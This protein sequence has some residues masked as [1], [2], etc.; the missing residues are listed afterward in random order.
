MIIDIVT[1]FATFG[2]IV[3][4][5]YTKL[6]KIS[7]WLLCQFVKRCLVFP[8]TSKFKELKNK[9]VAKLSVNK[10]SDDSM[11]KTIYNEIKKDPNLKIY[12]VTDE[13]ISI[14]NAL[15]Y[16]RNEIL[17]NAMDYI[18]ISKMGMELVILENEE[19][20]GYD[21]SLFIELTSYRQ[22]IFNA[23]AF[24]SLVAGFIA[25]A[26]C[27]SEEVRKIIAEKAFPFAT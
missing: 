27:G 9:P 6:E 7:A 8:K 11:I 21:R 4:T 18:V 15:F 2:T 16:D 25:F 13:V 3:A 14:F 20:G 22:A 10:F 19:K 5:F 24:V 23:H 26:V 1:I 12:G 17:L